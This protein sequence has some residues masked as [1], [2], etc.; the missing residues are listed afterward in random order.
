MK[1]LFKLLS[2]ALIGLALASCNDDDNTFAPDPEP[3]PAP[4]LQLRV[5]T[6]EDADYKGTDNG[7]KGFADWSSLIDNPQY[8]GPM[9]YPSTEEWLYNWND[10]DNTFLASKLTN[11]Y[12]D[13]K[14]WGGGHVISNYT[15]TDLANGDSDHQLAVYGIAGH[16]GSKNFCIHNGSAAES[17]TDSNLPSIYF[18][19]GIERVVDHMWVAN[20]T[21]ALNIMKNGD[22]FGNMPFGSQD[23]L[24]IIA[25]GID[26]DGKET[27]RSSFDLA[28]GT[29]FIVEWSRWDLASLG[30]V[31]KIA[32]N[33]E[34]SQTSEWGL[35]T[36][37]YFAYDDVAV[38]F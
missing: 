19:D 17:N 18:K 34:G 4:E 26:A 13:Y 35:N 25:I 8:N 20:T 31:A 3:E 2:V 38:Q 16:N 5:L 11:S 1:N 28:T 9:L 10:D 33:M 22:D 21:Y 6:F 23:Y 37:A 12:G 7:G 14:F 36:P 32:F 29:K 27:G 30:K 15:D 24:R